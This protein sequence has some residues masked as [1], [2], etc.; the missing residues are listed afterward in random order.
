MPLQDFE[1]FVWCDLG[2]SRITGRTFA[3]PSVHTD[4]LT[5]SLTPSVEHLSDCDIT[6]ACSA[7]QSRHIYASL[8][9]SVF[10]EIKIG[11]LVSCSSGLNLYNRFLLVWHK[12]DT[13]YN[14][15][16]RAENTVF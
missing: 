8:G 2:A 14:N 15:N 10:G 4:V 16:R 6:N 3:R 1:G 13:E 7:R 5:L 12:D 11:D 9:E